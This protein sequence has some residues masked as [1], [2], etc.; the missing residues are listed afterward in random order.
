MASGGRTQP[1]RFNLFRRR[2]WSST[3]L[4]LNPLPAASALIAKAGCRSP[5]IVTRTIDPRLLELNKR[6]FLN[7]H[8]PFSAL[9]SFLGVTCAV[10]L[11]YRSV[12]VS[13][14]RSSNEANVEFLGTQV[15]HQY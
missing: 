4:M 9:L 14:E 11:D 5:V 8:T 13:N 3:A 10:L 12:I 15:N 1:L 7:G 6:G 2:A